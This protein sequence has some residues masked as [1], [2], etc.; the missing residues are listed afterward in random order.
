MPTHVAT[1]EQVQRIY[2]A[3]KGWSELTGY[4]LW[5]WYNGAMEALTGMPEP[6]SNQPTSD[7]GR[8][9]FAFGKLGLVPEAL[10]KAAGSAC[11]VSEEELWAE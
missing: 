1:F 10:A 6:K 4:P 2:R 8:S 5:D 11:D 9:G 7:A 3:A